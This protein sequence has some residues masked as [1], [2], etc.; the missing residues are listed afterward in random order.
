MELRDI[1]IFLTLAEELHFGR[2]AERMRLTPARI[3]Q[4]IKKQERDLG[5]LLFER[6]SRTV[7]LTPLGRQLR[8]ELQPIRLA[9]RDTMRRA[10]A[11]AGGVT[12]TLRIGA[13]NGNGHDL[14]P[15][16][17]AFRARHPGWELRF[18]H[19]PFVDPFGGLRRGEVDVL[20]TWL[21]IAEPD[22]VMGPVL[23]TDER[24]LAVAL[25]HPLAARPSVTVESIAD[26]QHSGTTSVP[27]YWE[28]SF[29]PS[30]TPGGRP[31][32][33]GP[34]VTSADDI[35]TLVSTGE[36]VNV[37]PAHS[38]RYWARPDV[39]WLPLTGME[40]FSFGLVWRGEAEDD[41][42]RAL[43]AVVRDLGSPAF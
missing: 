31:I 29:V 35:L 33:R 40:R 11:A 12:A 21:P 34:L 41:V 22:L 43:A 13:M 36:I 27:D 3:S 8:D 23:F 14:R 39:L 20:V 9:L 7:R 26:F 16:W 25:D 18:R 38:A 2:T 24:V 37:F 15:Y 6:N 10:R 30:H 4:A 28:S 5:G 19:A 17:D 42:I 1:E 32:E